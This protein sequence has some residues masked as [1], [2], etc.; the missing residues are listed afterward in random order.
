[1]TRQ[2]PSGRT[3]VCGPA[4]KGPMNINLSTVHNSKSDCF[5]PLS[6]FFHSQTYIPYAC[7]LTYGYLMAL[8]SCAGA[9][10]DMLHVLLFDYFTHDNNDKIIIITL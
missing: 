1:M 7:N 9:H 3:K 6:F 5:N 10:K 2:I 8:T 4:G